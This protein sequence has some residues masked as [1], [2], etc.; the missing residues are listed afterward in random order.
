[1][2]IPGKQQQTLPQASNAFK[3]ILFPALLALS[4]YAMSSP[5]L[6]L[7]NNFPLIAGLVLLTLAT[8][9]ACLILAMAVLAHEAVH[10]VLFRSR[11]TNDLIGGVMS[12]LSLIPF[13]ANRQFH[14]SHHRYSHQ[15][16]LDPECRMH[17]RGYLYAFFVG[18]HMGIFLQHRQYLCN[19]LRGF[20]EPRYLLLFLKDSLYLSIAFGFYATLVVFFS[21]SPGYALLPTALAFTVVF[22]VRAMSDHFGLC[23]ARRHG[24]RFHEVVE[25][26]ELEAAGYERSQASGW[27]VLTNPFVEWLWSHVNYHDVHH[28]YPYLSHIHLKPIFEAT[29]EQQDYAIAPG[30]L[31]NLLRLRGKSYFREAAD[32]R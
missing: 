25:Q 28:R 13:H 12:A 7:A 11:R 4:L 16:G 27:V 18:P 1:M 3:A 23:A 31:N 8:V 2:T 32:N 14:L 30:Y 26:D 21:V 22:S 9:N 19:L 10:E 5:A 29:R 15:R 24:E 17:G 6:N 20:T